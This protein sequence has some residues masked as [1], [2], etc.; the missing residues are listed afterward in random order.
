MGQRGV[1]RGPSGTNECNLRR[2]RNRLE[3]ANAGKE[4]EQGVVL[5]FA[6]SVRGL[7]R[8]V[9]FMMGVVT[10]VMRSRRTPRLLRS[11]AGN[12]SLITF[13]K[14]VRSSNCHEFECVQE[15]IT[16][17]RAKSIDRAVEAAKRGIERRRRVVGGQ[18]HSDGFD[19][20]ID[21][22]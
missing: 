11:A 1:A 8:R 4:V 6:V 9:E 7:P 10:W 12:S 16:I 13:F 15:T 3:R 19:V 21:E 14:Y 18:L 17:E 20:K 5:A 22:C 2:A